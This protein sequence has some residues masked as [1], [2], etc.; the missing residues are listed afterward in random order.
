[1]R[2]EYTDLLEIRTSEEKVRFR[3]RKTKFSKIAKTSEFP[4][5]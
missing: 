4:N 3:Q 2:I 1:M 5:F